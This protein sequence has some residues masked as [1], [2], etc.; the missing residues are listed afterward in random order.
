MKLRQTQGALY[1][2]IV[3][4]PNA[5]PEMAQRIIQGTGRMSPKRRVEVY[6][7]QYPARMHE[8]LSSDF[9]KLAKLLKDEAFWELVHAYAAAFPSEH[10]DLGQ[11]GRKLEAFLRTHRHEDARADLADL[12]ALEW[13]RSQCFTEADASPV[14]RE[15]LAHLSP[16]AFVEARLQLIP[17]L[18]RLRFDYAV[19]PLWK[20]LDEGKRVPKP[21][22]AASFAVA[23]RQ[24]FAVFHRG[25]D[26][27]EAQALE[28]ANRG[29]PLGEVMAAFAERAD[30]APAAFQAFSRWVHDGLV[31]AVWG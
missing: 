14:G 31:S 21:K 20:A 3:G 26:A 22:A 5:R 19:V 24:D 12:A 18:R 17:A 10:H 29:A 11:F 15:A 16:E 8:S 13:A 6:A 28:A 2:L 9:P 23:W 1:K 30:A 27:D 4:A 25:I 7:D